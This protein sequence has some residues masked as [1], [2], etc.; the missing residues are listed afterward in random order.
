[1]PESFTSAIRLLGF[2]PELLGLEHYLSGSNNLV[3]GLNYQ[4]TP[5]AVS[6][7]FPKA[8]SKEKE[9]SY[10]RLQQICTY[11]TAK[12]HKGIQIDAHT[13][14]IF[15][16]NCFLCDASTKE[17]LGKL[18]A[19]QHYVLGSEFYNHQ[20]VFLV[21]KGA[22]A[23]ETLEH[24][25]NFKT[26][27]LQGL[28]ILHKSTGAV[29]LVDKQIV[30]QIVTEIIAEIDNIIKTTEPTPQLQKLIDKY[31]K[32]WN[33]ADNSAVKQ[34]IIRETLIRSE[35]GFDQLIARHIRQHSIDIKAH[36]CFIHGDAHGGNFI[37][38]QK[39]SKKE[40]HP[41]DVEEAMGLTET[42]KKHYLYDLIK[43]VVSA[44]NLSRIF[45]KP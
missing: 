14:F 36:Y 34:H 9:I 8:Y 21:K 29:K 17:F 37:I 44:Y 28:A 27:M 2:D 22:P 25:I 38:V 26:I 1:M 19:E 39:G 32:K 6:I 35:P 15:D 10:L 20:G 40:V 45:G 24:D 12:F 4:G 13:T 16:G 41:I 42:E 3:I 30:S 33:P 11:L 7:S 31:N 23:S 18:A 43:F 5:W